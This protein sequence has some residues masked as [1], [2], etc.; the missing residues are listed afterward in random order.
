LLSS[1]GNS[2]KYSKLYSREV[3]K[4]MEGYNLTVKPWCTFFLLGWFVMFAFLSSFADAETHY[5]EFV[6]SLFFI[7]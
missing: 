1:G 3:E 2:H 4:A 7:S 5:H 6:V